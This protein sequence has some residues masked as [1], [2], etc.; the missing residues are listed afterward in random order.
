MSNNLDYLGFARDPAGVGCCPYCRGYSC[1]RTASGQI[2]NL[3]LKFDCDEGT[4]D[5]DGDGI[6]DYVDNCPEIFN[7]D[8]KDTDANGI[9]DACQDSDRDKLID[10]IERLFI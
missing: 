4:G 9:G 5:S 6:P 1:S 2:N 7:I 8:Q 3:E 10:L